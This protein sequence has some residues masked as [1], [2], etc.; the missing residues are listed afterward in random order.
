[1][2]RS[3]SVLT[4]AILVSSFL[5][6]AEPLL[7]QD[8]TPSPTIAPTP[9]PTPIITPSPIPSPT[10][11]S[12]WTP[13]PTPNYSVIIQPSTPEFN[14]EFVDRSYDVP[15]TYTNYTDPYTG[16]QTT[17]KNGGNHVTNSTLD[18]SIKNQPFTSITLE[19]GNTP[20]LYYAVRWRGH[21]ENWTGEFSPDQFKTVKAS[22]SEFTIVTYVLTSYA[23]SES[24]GIHIPKGGQID[25]EVKAQAG[26]F[27]WYS[28][29]HI[30]PIGTAF[31]TIKESDWSAAQTFTY[32]ND[33][34]P[35]PTDPALKPFSLDALVDI[36]AI[37]AVTALLLAVVSVLL[38]RR[39]LKT[40]NSVNKL[41]I[42][43]CL[44][45]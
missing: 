35:F 26:Y 12:E 16:E 7:A 30:F 34:T 39:H 23:S 44:F 31:K 21:F 28:D 22:D 1:M 20:E 13:T 5:I 38:Y 18:L 32:P 15:I 9:S 37:T 36:I 24:G 4:V 42:K 41:L 14:V 45:F 33:P 25:F 10:S 17:I 29:G 43:Y 2:N 6:M 27:Y 19:D 3:L 40:A 8:P 11:P